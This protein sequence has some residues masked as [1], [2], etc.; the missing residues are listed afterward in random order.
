VKPSPTIF[1]AVLEE[2]G[3]APEAAVM[4][5]DSL[6]DDIEGAR[7]LGMRAFLVDRE[8]HTG[9]EDAIPTLLALPA[10]IGAEADA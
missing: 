5:G 8:G 6:Q 9:V 4:V 3:V 1:M 2:L 7:A 10:L